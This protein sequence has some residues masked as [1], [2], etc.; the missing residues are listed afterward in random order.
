M[1]ELWDNPKVNIHTGEF[2]N[3]LPDGSPGPTGDLHK[4]TLIA[5]AKK[6]AK[7]RDSLV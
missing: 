3:I 4:K 6:I 7:D 1:F 5:L 2:T